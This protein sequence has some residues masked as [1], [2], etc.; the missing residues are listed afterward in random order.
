MKIMLKDNLSASVQNK[1]SKRDMHA[2][3]QAKKNMA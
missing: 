1:T 2:S 3:F